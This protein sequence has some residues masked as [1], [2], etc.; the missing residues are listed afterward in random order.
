[1]EELPPIFAVELDITDLLL[2]AGDVIGLG[3]S[4]LIVV[5]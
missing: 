1:L 3:K 4:D 5:N 2:L